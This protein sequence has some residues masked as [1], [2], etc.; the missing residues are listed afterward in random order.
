MEKDKVKIAL[1]CCAQDMCQGDRCPY[2]EYR[3]KENDNCLEKMSKD[4]LDIIREMEKRIR[5]LEDDV[6]NFKSIAEYQQ[7]SNISRYFII[8]E[9]DEKI[10]ELYDEIARLKKIMEK[11]NG[12]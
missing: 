4:A 6:E 5:K 10:K 8:K 9:K 2:F 3:C 1:A 11:K 12:S 7:N